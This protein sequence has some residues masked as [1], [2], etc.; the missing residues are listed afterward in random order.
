MSIFGEAFANLPKRAVNT[1]VREVEPKT[2]KYKESRIN[3]PLESV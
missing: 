1:V 3:G 2:L